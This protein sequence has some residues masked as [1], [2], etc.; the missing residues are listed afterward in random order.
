[1]TPQRQSIT[2]GATGHTDKAGVLSW[3]H[4]TVVVMSLGL[5]LFAWYYSHNQLQAK[6]AVQFDREADHVVELVMERM[7]KYGDAL[8]AGVAFIDANGGEVDYPAWNRYATSIQIEKKYPGIDGIGIIR[9]LDRDQVPAFVQR[10]RREQPSFAI[11]PA[12]D[13]DEYWPITSIVPLQGN[14]KALGLD[15]AHETNRITAARKARDSGNEQITAPIVLVQDSMRTPGFLFYAP[16]YKPSVNQTEQAKQFAGLVYAPFVFRK[17]MAGTLQKEKRRVGI[18]VSDSSDVLFDEHVESDHDF[19]P[20]PL[21]KK[22]VAVPMYGRT[23]NFDIW[24]AKS[25]RQSVDSTKPITI[26][27]SGLIIDGLLIGLLMM[28]T[29]E[30]RRA[31]GRADELSADLEKLDLAARVNHIGIFDYDPVSG[32]L[33]WDEQMFALYGRSPGDFTGAY[34]VWS[35]S[36]H[37]D[38]RETSEKALNDALSD[39]SPFDCEFRVIHPDGKIRYIS[40]KAVVFRDRAGNPIRV[41]GAN[42]DVTDRNAEAREHESTRRLQSAILDAAGTAIIATDHDGLIVTFNDAAEQMLGYTKEEMLFQQNPGIFHDPGEVILRA[43]ELSEELGREVSPGFEVFVARASLG[44]SEQREWTYIRK[45]GSTLPVLLTVTAIHDQHGVVSGYLGIATDISERKRSQQKIERAN[46]S[47]A[48][49][50]EELAQFAYVASHDLQEPLRKVTS[51]CE[52]LK[53]DCGDQLTDDGNQYITYIV[54]GATRMRALIKDL[55]AYSRIESDELKPT[56]VDSNQALQAAMDNLSEAIRES[57]AK[58]TH[59][60]LPT[61]QATAGQF[62]QLLQ[63]LLGNA[64]KYRGDRTPIVHVSSETTDTLW[65]FAVEDNGI[66]IEPKFREQ[67]FGIFKRLHNR[68]EYA[69]TGIGLAVCKRI[70]DRLNGRIWIEQSPSGGTIF[71]FEFPSPT[72][73]SPLPRFLEAQTPLTASSP[74][75]AI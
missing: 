72:A 62:T 5:T 60:D 23:W 31:H 13:D 18:R 33:E 34:E 46:V 50:N 66:G 57:G 55:L 19:D 42:T 21:L 22:Q 59:D 20:V 49:S 41:L 54:D 15:M 10:R 30:S 67:V 53:E 51:F 24:S 68:N 36:L 58:I 73:D 4:W 40:A 65:Q 28:I 45:D 1:M 43:G 7:T 44:D 11:H 52:L 37:P 14:E 38:D 25:F 64:I 6:I 71:R 32:S 27:I 61:V 70:I 63:N 9:P 75:V 2:A 56:S 39:D 12:R 17:L 69:G 35:E 26:L 47:L 3:F 8:R 29:R 74:S 16:F 48:R